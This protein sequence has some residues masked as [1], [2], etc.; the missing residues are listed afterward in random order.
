MHAKSQLCKNLH[1]ILETQAQHGPGAGALWWEGEATSYGELARRVEYIAGQL[2]GWAPPGERVAVLAWNCPAFIEL[3]YAV[4]AAGHI[5]VPLNARLAPVELAWQLKQADV[6]LLVAD[7]T[8]LKPLAEHPD[9]PDEI[10]ALSL[11]DSWEEWLKHQTPAQLPEVSPADPA[12]ILYTS[13]TTDRPKG[14]LL[15]HGAFIAG[16]ESAALGRP[17]EPTDRY[18][19]AFPLFHVAA[20]NVLLQ[21][22]HGAAV[23]LQ[24]SFKAGEVLQACRELN[25]TTLSLAPTMIAMLLE[26]PDFSAADLAS[27]RTVGYGAAAMPLDLLQRLTRETDLGLCQGYGM[28]E[29]SGSVAFLTPEDHRLATAEKPQL[30]TSVGRPLTTA[31]ILIADENG[32][33]CQTGNSGEILVRAPQCMSGYWRD[34]KASAATVSAD[35][36]LHTGDIGRFDEEGYLYIVDRKKDMIVTGGE[37]VASREVEDVIRQHPAVQD[38]AVI[39]RPDKRWGEAVCSVVVLHESITD[40]ALSAHCRKSLA[41]YKTPKIWLRHNGLPI[42]AGGKIDKTALRQLMEKDKTCPD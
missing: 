39:G 1:S 18:L 41:A 13:G 15:S 35:G 7:E 9:F 21:H 31:E 34:P 8:L 6:G 23:V 19:Y 27:V 5:L 36:W 11:G 4:S 25:V 40:E 28:T 20:H 24:A 2:A 38:C 42:N 14:A 33:P 32:A 29:L 17:V 3:I 37:N 12:W 30:L 22:Q 16:L 26:H 10:T